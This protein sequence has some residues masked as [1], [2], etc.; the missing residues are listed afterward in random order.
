M[1]L[2]K[3]CLATFL[4]LFALVSC[5]DT[6]FFGPIPNPWFDTQGDLVRIAKAMDQQDQIAKERERFV[7][8]ISSFEQKGKLSNCNE[9]KFAGFDGDAMPAQDGSKRLKASAFNSCGISYYWMTIITENNSISV[10]KVEKRVPVSGDKIWIK[11]SHG[12]REL[13][14]LK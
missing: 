1:S 3:Q 5:S 8:A 12:S 9:I 6:Q 2:L 11:N 10:K 7:S 4:T 13:T 14:T